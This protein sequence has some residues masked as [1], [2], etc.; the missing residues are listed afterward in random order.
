MLLLHVLN[1]SLLPEFASIVIE[2][3]IGNYQPLQ[4][5][6]CKHYSYSGCFEKKLPLQNAVFEN[7]NHIITFCFSITTTLYN[8]TSANVLQIQA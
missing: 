8:V 1:N 4:T 7:C 5:T 3:V 2:I 6:I